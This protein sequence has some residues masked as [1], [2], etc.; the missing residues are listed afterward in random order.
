MATELHNTGTMVETAL[1]PVATAELGPTLMHEHIV[2]RSPGVHENWPHLFDRDAVLALAERKMADLGSRGI[3]T[4]VDLTTVDL[5]RDIDLI[6]AVAR[7]SRVR[8]IVATGV[9]WMPQRYFS[10]HGVDAT[11]LAASAR[12][13]SRRVSSSAPRTRPA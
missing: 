10:S 12:A 1:G 2:T 3:R 7:R 5:G 13:V 4:I 9:W 11:S 8:V 6:V